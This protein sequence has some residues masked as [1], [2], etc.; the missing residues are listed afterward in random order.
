MSAEA[1]LLLQLQKL[2]L[3]ENHLA[4]TLPSSWAAF[5][6]SHAALA[7]LNLHLLCSRCASATRLLNAQVLPLHVEYI[8][9]C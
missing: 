8:L 6:V 4:G 5:Q 9:L 3:S 7:S 1:H 2:D